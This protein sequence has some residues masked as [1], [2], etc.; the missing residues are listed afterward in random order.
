M[1]NSPETGRKDRTMKSKDVL[2]SLLPVLV[3]MFENT[4]KM[5]T[6][7]ETLVEHDGITLDTIRELIRE[8]RFLDRRIQKLE[9][10]RKCRG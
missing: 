6:I 2:N 8:V 9:K 3:T 7:T 4:N 1:I 5:A 10:E